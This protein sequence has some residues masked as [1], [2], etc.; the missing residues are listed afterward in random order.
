VVL[1][2]KA[3]RYIAK[4]NVFPESQGEQGLN[5]QYN[6]HQLIETLKATGYFQFKYPLG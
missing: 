2:S 3:E 4:N 1:P 6:L 5:V